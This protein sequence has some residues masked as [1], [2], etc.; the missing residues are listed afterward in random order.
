[1]PTFPAPDG[2]GLAYR[3]IGAGEPLLCLPGPMEDAAYLGD[4][5]GLAR[6]RELVLLDPRGTGDSAIPGDPASY[7]CDRQVDDVEAWRR[8]LGLSRFDLLAHSAG[9]NLAVQYAIRHP[10]AVNRLV[11]I[12]PSLI[13]VGIPVTG[14]LRRETARLREHE[15]WYPAAAAALA[16]IG[17]GNGTDADWAAIAP[18]RYGRWDAAAQRQHARS[19]SRI[20]PA[21]AEAF[22]A[23]GAFTPEATRAAL[24]SLSTPVLALAGEFDLNSPPPAVTEFAA[25]FPGATLVV[26]PEAGHQPWLDDPD[27]FVAAVA[28]FL[29]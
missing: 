3:T 7:R 27:R 11:L 4:L 23:D 19:S 1:M 22:G 20:N 6:H 8:H 9:A 15:P 17:A 16:A 13:G 28:S 2:T 29:A 21:A 18:L 10:D 25:L 14:E 26:Q 12:T 24:A 5:G